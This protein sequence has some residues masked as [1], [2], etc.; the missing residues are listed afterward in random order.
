MH[1]LEP[2]DVYTPLGIAQCV[3]IWIS[4]DPQWCCWIHSTGENWWFGNPHIRRRLT[5]THSPVRH[6]LS[7]YMKINKPLQRQIERYKKNGWLPANY[8]PE[9]AETWPL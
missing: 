4:E 9:D 1:N 6:G 3:G 7:S 5:A 8:N 2:F